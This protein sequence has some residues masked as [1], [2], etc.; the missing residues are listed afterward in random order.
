MTFDT[1]PSRERR[2]EGAR[3]SSPA[4]VFSE[5]PIRRVLVFVIV[6]LALIMSA[7]DSTIVATALHAL[8]HGLHTT[9]NWAG[10]TLTGYAF[11]LVI[12]LPITGKLGERYGGRRIF[13]ASVAMFTLS[14]LLCGLTDNIYLLI[15][16]RVVQAAGGAG[17]TPS[18]TSIIVNHF[19]GERDRAVSLF[20]AIFPIGAMIGPI[21]GGI[22]VTYWSWRAVFFVNV[23]IGLVIFTLAWRY[24]PH[25]HK[26]APAQERPTDLAGMGL[27]AIGLLAGMLAISALA[28]RSI[29]LYSVLFLAPLAISLAGGTL[30]WRHTRRSAHPFIPARLLTGPGFGSVNLVN[31]IYS[32]MA[33][34]CVALAPLYATNRYGINALQSG[35]L[36]VAQG[37]AQTVFSVL[38]VMALRRTGYHAPLYVGGVLIGAGILLFALPP[39]APLSPYVWLASAAFLVGIGKGITNPASRNAGLH[40][41]PDHSATIAAI[42]TLFIQVGSI[43]TVAVATAILADVRDPGLSQAWVYVAAALL[44]I[45]ALPVI[46][47]VPEHRGAW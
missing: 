21:F 40:L 18:A 39:L 43:A 30:F 22:L 34:G 28:E 46:P 32:G 3:T 11:G 36:L 16:L 33:V 42:R 8:Q 1:E 20:G 27:M 31:A 14:S 19:G 10:W 25:D 45:A 15:A 23:P 41:A 6:A 4:P 37:I 44:F 7:I 9:I 38:A 47:H 2:A 13:I 5:P 17:F 35:T 26:R 24:I 12:M 29:H